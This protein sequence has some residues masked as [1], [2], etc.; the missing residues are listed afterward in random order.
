VAKKPII[1]LPALITSAIVGP[2]SAVIGM[3][4]N[5][6]GSGMGTSGLVGQLNAYET[7]SPTFGSAQ[8][9]L[10]IAIVHV[11]LPAV[12]SLIISEF[13]RKKGYIK[14]GDMKLSA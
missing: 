10:L 5:P 3:T 14:P 12:L 7:M 2:I 6:T 13:M 1:W 11:L 9:L 8:T 4:N